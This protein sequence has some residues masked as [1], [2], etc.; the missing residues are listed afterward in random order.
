MSLKNARREDDRHDCFLKSKHMN[1]SKRG[2]Y[3]KCITSKVLEY[4]IGVFWD[5]KP[6]VVAKQRLQIKIVQSTG[7][8]ASVFPSW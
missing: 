4:Q 3:G 5:M 2:R 8:I 7:K 6:F 1:I